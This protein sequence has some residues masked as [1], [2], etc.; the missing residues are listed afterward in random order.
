GCSW[1][2]TFL[3]SMRLHSREM[4]LARAQPS[5]DNPLNRFCDLIDRGGAVN[6][7]NASR[8]LLRDPKITSANCP[9][10]DCAFEIQPIHSPGTSFSFKPYGN[11]EVQ[12]DREVR[13][14]PA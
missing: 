9:V 8:L 4:I 5:L 11:R 6:Y 12:E 10:K 7:L 1:P 3:N 13:D 14:K 2:R